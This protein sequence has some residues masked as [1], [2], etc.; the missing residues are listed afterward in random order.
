MLPKSIPIPIPGGLHPPLPQFLKVAQALETRSVPDIAIT[1]RSEFAKFAH[2]NM[3]GKSI[4]IAVGSRGIKD[5][6]LVVQALIE[7]LKNAGALPFIFP[8][9]GSH[10]GGTA[11]GQQAVLANYGY[12]ES[13]LKVPIR[14]SMGVVEIGHLDNGTPVYC[15]AFAH[16]A[17]WIIPVNRVKPHTSFRAKH[18]SGMAKMLA[19]G[20]AKHAG[21]EAMHFHGAH[22]FDT[23]IP[24]AAQIYLDRANVLFGVGIVENAVEDIL[25]VELVPPAN[26][27]ERDAALLELAKA[28]IPQLLFN[29]IDVLIIDKIG[30]NISGSG[31]DPNVTGRPSSGLPGFDKGL[32]IDR[33]VIRDLTDETQGNACGLGTSDVTT[34]R[35]LQK[36]DWTKTYVNMVTAGLPSGARLPIVAN[37]DREAIGIALRG[38]PGVD[39][40]T[41]RIVRIANTLELTDI[42]VSTPMTKDVSDHPRLSSIGAPFDLG[43]DE[44]N[45]LTG[46]VI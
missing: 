33:I 44:S 4:A 22:Q 34:Q 6:F 31:L 30:K 1:I 39:S 10:G 8:A 28:T 25:Q 37:T 36:V 35:L 38:C 2:L 3:Q 7:C 11:E 24:A 40:K 15:D 45:A 14:A 17:D 43:F 20:I 13:A 26:L 27:L 41:A 32:K 23:M 21:A 29:Q 42:W 19:V 5:Q 16:A 46:Q 18:E 9:M 12:T